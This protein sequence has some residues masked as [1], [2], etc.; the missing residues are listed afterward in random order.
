MRLETWL[1]QPLKEG[2]RTRV[3]LDQETHARS[4]DA[5]QSVA[6]STTRHVYENSI[7]LA[8]ASSSP[9]AG[10]VLGSTRSTT[11]Q[12]RGSASCRAADRPLLHARTEAYLREVGGAGPW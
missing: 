9:R 5:S 1:G 6:P 10:S 11:Q 7:N 8:T 2:W 12:G 3:V 4:D